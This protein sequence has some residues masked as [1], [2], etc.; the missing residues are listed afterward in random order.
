MAPGQPCPGA[1]V[2]LEGQN[3]PGRRTRPTSPTLRPP[4]R[5]PCRSSAHLLAFGTRP[6]NGSEPARPKGELLSP[7]QHHQQP[8]P[9]LVLTTSVVRR[10]ESQCP[11]GEQ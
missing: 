9:G 4:C 3:R 2:G 11:Y 5:D 6:R 7:R 10:D 1:T 8:T